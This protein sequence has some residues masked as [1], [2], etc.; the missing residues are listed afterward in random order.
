MEVGRGEREKGD[1]T[2]KRDEERGKLKGGRE[3]GSGRGKRK[4]GGE[5]WRG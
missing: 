4:K 5:K 3:K 2:G 1:R